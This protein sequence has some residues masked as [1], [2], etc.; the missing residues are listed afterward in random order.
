[1]MRTAANWWPPEMLPAANPSALFNGAPSGVVQPRNPVVAIALLFRG[2]HPAGTAGVARPG[3]AQQPP[4]VGITADP[5]ELIF[6]P[7][8][9]LA[10]SQFPVNESP[11]QHLIHVAASCHLL[12][13]CKDRGCFHGL[14]PPRTLD[15]F[16]E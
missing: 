4:G 3:A 1:M 7:S 15:I 11:Y 8:A 12:R 6:A 2:D 16:Q 14:K 5:I 10:A 9:P 13:Y